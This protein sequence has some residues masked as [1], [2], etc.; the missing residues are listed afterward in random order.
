V[1]KKK[2][3]F[4]FCTVRTNTIQQFYGV[5]AILAASTNVSTYLVTVLAPL[6]DMM[7]EELNIWN[8]Y[9]F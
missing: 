5:L 2:Q 4:S 3:N 6:W 7:I 1:F 8:T 9:V